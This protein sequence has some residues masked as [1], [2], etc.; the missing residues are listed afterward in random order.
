MSAEMDPWRLVRSLQDMLESKDRQIRRLEEENSLL[1]S[2][3]RQV[4]QFLP[5]RVP[6]EISLSEEEAET[7]RWVDKSRRMGSLRAMMLRAAVRAIGRRGGQP[8]HEDDII[9]EFMRTPYARSVEVK[10]PG[11]TLGRRLRELREAGY[12]ASPKKGYYTIG[13]RSAELEEEADA[14]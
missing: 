4:V 9:R 5:I 8:V 14:D 10:S 11:E 3:L 1:R 13:Q 2:T 6:D 12:L 7:E